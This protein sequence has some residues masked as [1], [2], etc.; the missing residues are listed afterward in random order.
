MKRIAAMILALLMAFSLVSCSNAKNAGGNDVVAPVPKDG[1]ME[2]TILVSS[3][4]YNT[5]FKTGYLADYIAKFE[6]DFGVDIK[7]EEIKTDNSAVLTLEEN[8]EYLKKLFT[9]LA[10]KDG[11]DLIFTQ[12]M[13]LE[14]L[15][16]QRA[17]VDLRGKV[18]NIDKI[19]DSLIGDEV[20]YVPLGMMY[21]GM[22]VNRDTLAELGIGE[23]EFNWMPESYYDARDKW[24]SNNKIILNGFEYDRAYHRFIDLDSLYN[25]GEKKVT[26]NTPEVRRKINDLRSYIFGGKYQLIEDYKYENYYN[27]LF[28]D[29]SK[30]WNDSFQSY[31]KNIS[32]GHLD[33]GMG[34]NILRAD[35]LQKDIKKYAIVKY[36]EDMAYG[37]VLDSYG[38][39]VNKNGKDLDI[40]YEFI[41]GLLSNEVQMS[42]FESERD[43]YPVNKEIEADIIKLEA[44]ENVDSRAVQLKAI[45]LQELKAGKCK[46]WTTANTD[47]YELAGMIKRDL[48]KLVLA[49]NAYS[50]EQLQVELK[51]MEDKYNIYLK[52]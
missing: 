48:A 17:V 35:I 37:V 15:I 16:E 2:I 1:Q 9:K 39:L 41:N 18:A 50:D 36:P 33:A 14:P 23:P 44:K 52:E 42:M 6:R 24:I 21:Y 28:E 29:K 49:D 51:R 26:L 40:A 27:M 7:F 34:M 45:A 3:M 32:N 12:N 11:P 10:T 19:Y 47:I 25:A 46:L 30:E 20:Y 38:F 22:K 43:Y 5:L 4:D 31:L 13:S 8:S